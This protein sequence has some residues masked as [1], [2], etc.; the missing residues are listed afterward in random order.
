[1]SV[2]VGGCCGRGFY[3]IAQKTRAKLGSWQRV[4]RLLLSQFIHKSER[5]PYVVGGDAVFTLYVL[6]CHAAGQTAHN[7]RYRQAGALNDG[8]AVTD[9]RVDDNAVRVGHGDSDGSDLDGPVEFGCPQ[10]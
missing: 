5:G 8:F 4:I 6:E 2:E 7:Y 9:G 1:M 10:R 3:S